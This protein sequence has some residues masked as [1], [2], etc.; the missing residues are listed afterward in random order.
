MDT[1]KL[2]YE[3]K[4][5]EVTELKRVLS[6]ETQDKEDNEAHAATLKDLQEAKAEVERANTSSLEL[7]A[8]LEAALEKVKLHVA[9]IDDL[10]AQVV[11]QN[12]EVSKEAQNN[13]EFELDEAKAEI[14]RVNSL[15]SE[16]QK[17]L[18]E[19]VSHSEKQGEEHAGVASE[20]AQTQAMLEE[21]VAHSEEQVST[22]EDLKEHL[23]AA[24]AVEINSGAVS[25]LEA[26]LEAAKTEAGTV[27]AELEAAKSK[28]E[29]A[30]AVARVA[31]DRS[32]V[33][34]ASNSECKSAIANMSMEANDLQKIEI[35]LRQEISFLTAEINFAKARPPPGP[36]PSASTPPPPPPTAP[37]SVSPSIKNRM[38][39]LSN[40]NAAQ[41]STIAEHES[42]IASLEATIQ[43]IKTSIKSASNPDTVIAPSPAF[44][45]AVTKYTSSSTS[46]TNLPSLG[47]S[48][49][50]TMVSD[51]LKSGDK[52]L[53]EA[54]LKKLLSKVTLQT[55]TNAH[56]LS[57][58][59]KVSNSI[60]VCCRIR[61]LK[62]SE[63][64]TQERVTVEPLSETEVGCLDSK[65]KKW[66]S[67]IFDKVFGP[68][69]TQQDVF[70]EVEPLCLS[71]VDGFNA[72]IFAYGQTGSGKTFTMEGNEE[73]NQWGICTRTLH[74]VFE[75]LNL[76]RESFVASPSAA[77]ASDDNS[78]ECNF[79]FNIELGMLEIYNDDVRDI[80]SQDVISVDLKRDLAGKIQ[81]QG[82]TKVA[83]KNLQDVIEV[84]KRGNNNRS[85]ACTNINDQSSRSHMV[86]QATIVS[87]TTGQPQTTGQLNLV[88]LAGSERVAKSNVVGKELK[89]AQHIN[90]S[91]SALGDV[92]EALDKKSS[93]IPYRNS[94]LTY[95]LQDSLG[96]NSRTMMIVTACPAESSVDETQCALQFATRVRRISKPTATRNVGGKNLEET[97]KK[98]RGELREALKGRDKSD[99]ELRRIQESHGKL[100]SR[101]DTL[102]ATK[103]KADLASSN[104]VK[105]KIQ[106]LQKS[107][108]DVSARWQKEKNLREEQQIEVGNL[109]RE[110]RRLQ[111]QMS[112]AVKDRENISKKLLEREQQIISAN[113]ENKANAKKPSTHAGGG[114]ER[115]PFSLRTTLRTISTAN[116]GGEDPNNSTASTLD[117]GA[118]EVR[119][120][121]K[122]ML[123]ANEPLKLHKLDEL[124]VKF[125]GKHM[126]LLAKMT[127]RYHKG[128][129]PKK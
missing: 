116:R 123:Q 36:P 90:L 103:A 61:P 66:R 33:L 43:K 27:K 18:E 100:K 111:Q 49:L 82:L 4:C 125:E 96:G 78:S 23:E 41:A 71:V 55:A 93:H 126:T 122:A 81:A 38:K 104:S 10:Q 79:D 1:L 92:M 52:G 56:L 60:Q 106:I 101:L 124:M 70:E 8:H 98:I 127:K 44:S 85:V 102:L 107:H 113:R 22:I 110:I 15:Y 99:S 42:K 53:M 109:E 121:I 13:L 73:D 47:Q 7:K 129:T 46:S 114:A 19:A 94:K 88:D 59:Q 64:V 80:L 75:I 74:K 84:M 50:K 9:E 17:M 67:Y 115:S 48:A 83:V 95:F 51:A 63:I 3:D 5:G 119:Q 12:K 30:E 65:S 29:S 28:L 35:D 57:K 32:K 118:E 91:L 11:E 108:A 6:E 25:E 21:A 72:C 117:I 31:T 68:D 20:L 39:S 16:S 87:G 105:S 77:D 26:K 62:H 34:E 120:K 89:E 2:K 69:Q 14:E 97:L 45:P 86:L 40:L 58:M 37:K 54:A 24:K 128:R 76:R 112:K